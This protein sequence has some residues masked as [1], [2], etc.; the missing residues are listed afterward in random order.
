MPLEGIR[1]LELGTFHAGPGAT[2]I[3][4]HLGAEVVKIEDAAGDPMRTWKEVGDFTLPLANGEGFP[5]QLSNR[6]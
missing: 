1:I 3:L 2:A 6:R 4:G 5:F